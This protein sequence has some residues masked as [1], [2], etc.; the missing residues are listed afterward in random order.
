METNNDS[1]EDGKIGQIVDESLEPGSESGLTKLEPRH[2]SIHFVEEPGQEEQKGASDVVCIRSTRKQESPG[3]CHQ[4]AGER[5]RIRRHT[6]VGEEP[7]GGPAK[8]PVEVRIDSIGR[9]AGVRNQ[10]T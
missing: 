4:Q 1:C 2:H 7:D 6:S 5:Y 8:A 10:E 3:N 9:F